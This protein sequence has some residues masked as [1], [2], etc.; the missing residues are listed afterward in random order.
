MVASETEDKR[1]TL[2]PAT[3]RR[4]CKEESPTVLKNADDIGVLMV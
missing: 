4:I 3:T 2:P 1:A